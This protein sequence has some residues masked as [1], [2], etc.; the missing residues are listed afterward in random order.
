MTSQSSTP[1]GT[2]RADFAA[3]AEDYRAA[4]TEL[5]ATAV[6]LERHSK[7][8]TIMAAIG[9]LALCAAFMVVAAQFLR[10]GL[11]P[12]V[13][14]TVVSMALIVAEVWV[15]TI[16][17]RSRARI[18]TARQ[19]AE[20]ARDGAVVLASKLETSLANETPETKLSAA[21]ATVDSVA[22][23]AGGIWLDT[24]DK[25]KAKK[26]SAKRPS[27]KKKVGDINTRPAV[28]SVPH[29]GGSAVVPTPVV[30]RQIGL[31][32]SATSSAARPSIATPT[33]RPRA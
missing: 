22:F 1:R 16:G 7:R 32:T 12:P 11:L 2:S 31:P 5:C 17:K 20:R 33:G 24:T 30:T 26:P 4:S 18:A 28:F 23:T 3:I 15:R 6:T 21:I 9:L 29:Q 10:L 13:L 14:A 25:P 27:A 19:A 8:V